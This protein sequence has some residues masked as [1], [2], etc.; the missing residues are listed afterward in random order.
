MM[1]ETFR[2]LHFKALEYPVLEKNRKKFSTLL[3]KVAY[4]GQNNPMFNKKYLDAPQCPIE[5]FMFYTPENVKN[6]HSFV[7]NDNI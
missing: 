6:R 1:S 5:Q 2:V 7:T 3:K 4:G